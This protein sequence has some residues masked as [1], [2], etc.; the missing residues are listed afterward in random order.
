M[1]KIISTLL[2]AGLAAVSCSLYETENS[3]QFYDKD[4]A[5]FASTDAETRTSIGNGEEGIYRMSWSGGDK[6]L[7]VGNDGDASTY[8]TEDNGT[9][10]AAFFPEEGEALIDPS[11]GMIAG[12]PTEDMYISS[13]D[14]AEPIYF[15]IPKIQNYKEGTFD[16]DVMPMI[17]DISYD[18]K[19]KF[20]N[21]AGVLKIA[22]SSAE[23]NV[24]VKTI[25]ISGESCI[26]GECG[27][28]PESKS[29]FFDETMI[30]SKKVTLD[31][32]NGVEVGNDEVA[33]FIVVPHQEYSGLEITVVTDE[34]LEQTFRMKADKVLDVKRSSMLTIP[35]VLDELGSEAGQNVEM[36]LG[37]VGYDD[38]T[39][40]I[41]IKDS[42][43]YFA[44]LQTK[45]SFENDLMSGYL[46]ESLPYGTVRKDNFSFSGLISSFFT[47]QEG[48]SEVLL[49]PGETYIL[50]IV[51]KKS[52]AAY[53]EEDL[54]TLEIKMN[55]FTSG[56]T[57]EVSSE[58]GEE[59][60]TVDKIRVNVTAS[61]AMYIYC[62]LIPEE[63][64][65]EYTSDQEVIEM[66][67]KPGNNSIKMNPSDRFIERKPL[68]P[69]K[70]FVFIAVAIDRDGHYGPLHMKKYSTLAIDFNSLTVEIEKDIKKLKEN[71]G[72]LNWSVSNGEAASYRYFYKKTDN[73]YWFDTFA[74]DYELVEAKMVFDPGLWYFNNTTDSSMKLDNPALAEGQEYVFVILAVADDGSCSRADYWTFT[75]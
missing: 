37:N 51:V 59:D 55:S 12:Y 44:G 31:C 34:D 42:A 49:E 27:Y 66:M 71:G 13:T 46:L 20:S 36:R 58:A 62:Q 8:S 72:I 63:Y 52:G 53:T 47:D 67:L 38:F 54:Y 28:I 40:N 6:I 26:S 25:E 9:P 68:K 43:P 18:N 61:G 65:A 23:G 39:V 11:A 24:T 29:Y 16:D 50:W 48:N 21:A 56:G 10:T 30:S 41:N 75:Y 2:T 32:G 1:K 57:I 7:I 60:I 22:L 19:L 14:P 4:Q 69:E 35:L 5:V 73:I 70:E 74:K 15:T 64:L 17:S 3:T 45:K 33:F